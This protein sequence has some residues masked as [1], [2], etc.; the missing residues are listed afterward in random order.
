AFTN[1][2]SPFV[3]S[4]AVF[5]TLI[6]ALGEDRAYPNS[7]RR[8]VGL[9]A[10]LL[11]LWYLTT[12]L[13]KGQVAGAELFGC[14]GWMF[15]FVGIPMGGLAVARSFRGA[16]AGTPAGHPGALHPEGGDPTE[17][18]TD[19]QA[20]VTGLS[21]RLLVLL[22]LLQYAKGL[23]HLVAL[24]RI[25]GRWQTVAREQCEVDDADRILG[26]LHFAGPRFSP[27]GD[28]YG[29]VF[30]CA[31]LYWRNDD[32]TDWAG[33]WQLTYEEL[34]ECP[35]VNHGKS[36]Y[37]GDDYRIVPVAGGHAADCEALTALLIAVRDHTGEQP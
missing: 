28:N 14:M 12:Q 22:Q 7:R 11:A 33:E 8:F 9:A 23:P 34:A 20:E 24:P 21:I 17:T 15:V 37:L 18:A 26:I 27:D 36:V 5:G 2:L 6:V 32:D 35:V 31:G 25:S 30:G 1:S 10:I 4:S 13:T 29:L 3:L 19:S 16:D